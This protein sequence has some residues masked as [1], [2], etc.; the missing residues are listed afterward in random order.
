MALTDNLVAYW[1][2]DES[3]GSRADS[4]G[5]NT[6]T[7]NNTVTGASGV[8]GTAAQF[9]RANS[10]YLSR[11]SNSDLETG[12]VDFTLQAWVYLDSKPSGSQ[13][14]V[15]D[16]YQ[17]GSKEYTLLYYQSGDRFEWAVSAD[18]SADSAFVDANNFGAPTTGTWYLLHAWHDSVNNQIGLAVNAGTPDTASYSGGIVV[19]ASAF[20]IGRNVSS[21]FYWDGRLDEVGLWKRVLSSAE[22]AQLYNGGAGL[23]YPFTS[24]AG[25]ARRRRPRAAVV[26]PAFE[27][28]W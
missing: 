27:L 8:I 12:D 6:L 20:E 24:G 11:A 17:S 7:D 16:K 5:S 10:E 15:I 28:S 13:M 2:L 21:G 18:G 3:S 23:A 4:V 14:R 1:A 9:T 22:R 25:P 26:E 19:Q